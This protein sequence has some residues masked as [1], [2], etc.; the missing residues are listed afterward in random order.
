M[1]RG[2]CCGR[3]CF[4]PRGARRGA[5]GGR[6]ACNAR[7]SVGRDAPRILTSAWGG[8]ARTPAILSQGAFIPAVPGRGRK[9]GWRM[10]LCARR[11]YRGLYERQHPAHS[12]AAEEDL[13][14]GGKPQEE[15]ERD[16]AQGA[17]DDGYSLMS[18]VHFIILKHN[19]INIY[20][21]SK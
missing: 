6:V 11:D 5:V 9:A 18:D 17:N 1:G 19:I 16:G 7:R 8:R 13:R 4:L 10:S 3:S 15:M 2:E 12:S 20:F 14:R 21:S